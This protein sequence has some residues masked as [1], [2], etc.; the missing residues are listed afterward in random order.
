MA[1]WLSPALA[2]VG[3]SDREAEALDLIAQRLTST[4]TARL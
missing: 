4:D 1:R 2:A 3:I